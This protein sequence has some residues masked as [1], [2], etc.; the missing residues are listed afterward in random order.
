[1]E[2][3]L[4]A[5]DAQGPVQHLTAPLNGELFALF[6]RVEHCGLSAVFSARPEPNK[7]IML[8]IVKYIVSS[9]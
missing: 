4:C 5:S 8:N 2:L 3:V 7:F 6:W 9:A 1:M